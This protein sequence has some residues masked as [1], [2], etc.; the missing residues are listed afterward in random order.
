M[1][2]TVI[3]LQASIS[4]NHSEQPDLPSHNFE[5]HKIKSELDRR[6]HLLIE[7]AY[8]S[9]SNMPDN[10]RWEIKEYLKR[11]NIFDSYGDNEW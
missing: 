9:D 8:R 6:C 5:I 7:L 10:D 11:G 2:S 4:A 1:V 3:T